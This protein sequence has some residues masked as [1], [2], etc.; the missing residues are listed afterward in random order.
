MKVI[1]YKARNLCTRRNVSA[2]L[3]RPNYM[4]KHIFIIILITSFGCSAPKQ[5]NDDFYV[6]NK[7]VNLFAFVGKKIS[8]VGFNPNAEKNSETVYDSLSVH[9]LIKK[10]YIMDRGFRCKYVIIKN[11]FNDLKIDTIDFIAY[12]HYGNPGFSEHETVLL[13]VSKNLK[14]DSY[15]HQKYQFD[16]LERNRKGTFYGYMYD[17]IE[18][19]N[20]IVIKNKRIASLEDLFTKK[21]EE[22][23]KSL[24][25]KSG[26]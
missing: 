18:R 15:F 20:R 9:A 14:G 23:F 8:V 25:N 4:R 10:Y 12:D 5:L 1:G 19:K 7:D 24:F 17:R 6:E 16:Y 3:K 22:V 2:H 26:S 11:V 13:Y 21:K